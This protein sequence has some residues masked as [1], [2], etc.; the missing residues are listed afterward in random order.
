MADLSFRHLFETL[1]K[2]GAGGLRGSREG[3]DI[4]LQR[5]QDAARERR[6]DDQN[7]RLMERGVLE[8]MFRRSQIERNDA[9]ISD[10]N[11]E[12]E[13]AGIRMFEDRLN[14]YRSA[15]YIKGQN[16]EWEGMPDRMAISEWERN[17]PNSNKTMGSTVWVADP[18][19]KTESAFQ[20]NGEGGMVPLLDTTTGEQIRQPFTASSGKP[21]VAE[22]EAAGYGRRM[23]NA[24]FTM[25]ALE[26]KDPMIA[27]RV[28]NKMGTASIGG[29]IPGIGKFIERS[30]QSGALA[31]MTS[32]EQ[33]YYDAMSDMSNAILRNATG[34]QI[35]SDEIFMEAA[36]YTMQ[37]GGDLA[38]LRTKQTRRLQNAMFSARAGGTAFQANDHELS[39]E[40][41]MYWLNT[42]G[43]GGMRPDGPLPDGEYY[44]RPIP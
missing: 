40:A 43:E 26:Q 4:R 13:G 44:S 14:E 5:E 38:T 30:A 17:N 27:K 11:Y 9:Y 3:T 2:M 33:V 19:G 34:A 7:T 20:S 10:L 24:H 12:R 28:A 31:A 8:D 36:P 32:D 39:A 22:V 29:T 15:Q 41:R 37:V 25:S 21:S 23:L 42:Q 35:R 16:P 18:G 6:L 1:G